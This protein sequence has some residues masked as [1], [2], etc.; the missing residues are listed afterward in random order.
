[1]IARTVHA[2]TRARC[3][4]PRRLSHASGGGPIEGGSESAHLTGH[5]A[6]YVHVSRLGSIVLIGKCP[7]REGRVRTIRGE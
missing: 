6:L 4:G 7:C 1:M 2:L 3:P 5:A